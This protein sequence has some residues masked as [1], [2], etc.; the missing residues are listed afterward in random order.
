MRHAAAIRTRG[1]SAFAFASL[2]LLLNVVQVTSAA[3]Q[4]SSA[5]APKAS[6]RLSISVTAVTDSSISIAWSSRGGGVVGYSVF[7]N[8]VPITST[9]DH[10]YTFTGL[11]CATSHVLGV[12]ALRASGND[13]PMQTVTASTGACTTSRDT[14]P[15]SVPANLRVAATSTSAVTIAWDPSNDNVAVI[16]YDVYQGSTHVAS[17]TATSSALTGLSCATT[18]ALYVD[19]F[20]AAGNTSPKASLTVRTASCP[21]TTSEPPPI[22]GLGYHRVLRDDFN[23]TELDTTSWSP[24]EFWE[25]VPRPGAVVV[26]DGTVKINNLFPYIGDQSIST[27]PYW[28][29]EAVKRSWMFGYFEARMKFTEARGSWPAFWLESVSH[30]Q[31]DERCPQPDLNFELDVMEYQGDEPNTFYGSEH[32]NTNGYCGASNP[33]R[34]VITQPKKLGGD[35]HTYAVNWTATNLTWYVD[36]VQQGLPQALFDSGAQQMFI[37]L[38]MQACGWDSSNSCTALTPSPL[39]TEV[40]YVQVWQQ[41]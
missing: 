7:L 37:A 4:R 39:V 31:W 40:D 5:A 35:W 9:S 20:D 14:V 22:A 2:V 24:K 8:G 29:G 11:S 28:G 13:S 30:S 38:T 27:G 26:S 18:Y 21:T 36:D 34:G 15:P 6:S 32:R 25:S 1:R 12:V 3:A 16:G 33:A 17:P 41:S 19:A 23:G 10:A